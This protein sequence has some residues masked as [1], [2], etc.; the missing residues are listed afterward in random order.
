VTARDFERRIAEAFRRRGFALTGFGTGRGGDLALRRHGGRFL[1]DL[2]HWRA[3]R[4]GLIAVRELDAMVRGVGA[5]GGFVITLGEFTSEARELARGTRIELIDGGA[6]DAEWG[7]E[8][9]AQTVG[10]FEALSPA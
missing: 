3:A 9:A 5:S 7:S 1:V 4:V 6:L 2:K 10:C 8:P